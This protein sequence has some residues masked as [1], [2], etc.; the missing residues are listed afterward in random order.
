[1]SC[2]DELAKTEI[3]VDALESQL[4]KFEAG[5]FS[6]TTTLDG[7]AVMANFVFDGGHVEYDYVITSLEQAGKL[8]VER[9]DG[10]VVSNSKI[11]LTENNT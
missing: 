5:S 1:M 2:Y 7:K 11:I 9:T 4:N 10:K 3:R 8:F 6:D